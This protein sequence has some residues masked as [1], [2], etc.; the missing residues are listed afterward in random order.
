[1]ATKN[2]DYDMLIIGFGTDGF[3]ASVTHA[4]PTYTQALSGRVS[5]MSYH[6]RIENKVPVNKVLKLWL[7]YDNKFAIA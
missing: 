3:V 7:G 2:Y 5:Q 1:M 6:D 4:Y